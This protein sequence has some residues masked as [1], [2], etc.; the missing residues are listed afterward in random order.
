M[1]RFWVWLFSRPHLPITPWGVISWWELRRIAF[2]GMVGVYGLIFLITFL[3]A[4]TT[5]GHLERGEVLSSPLRYW[6]HRL[7]SICYTR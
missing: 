4:V 2:N 5:S 1:K 3:W 6:R 7:L